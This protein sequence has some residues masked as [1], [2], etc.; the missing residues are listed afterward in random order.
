MAVRDPHRAVPSHSRL[1]FTSQQREL[2]ATGHRVHS[3]RYAE[4]PSIVWPDLGVGSFLLVDDDRVDE[5][6]LNRMVTFF[7]AD[8]EAKAFNG[9]SPPIQ[10]IRSQL[11]S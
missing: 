4:C 9:S 6:N 7:P 8:A 3:T 1:G 10:R 5:S 2:L 11:S